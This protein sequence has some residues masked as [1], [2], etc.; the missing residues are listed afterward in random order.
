MDLWHL[1]PFDSGSPNARDPGPSFSAKCVASAMRQT[2]PTAMR[3]AA[4]RRRS[5]SRISCAPP[6]C[7]R[8][9][10][11]VPM[12][13]PSTSLRVHPGLSSCA[14]PGRCANSPARSRATCWDAFA[15]M[16]SAPPGRCVAQ[17][18]ARRTVGTRFLL[19]GLLA[20]RTDQKQPRIPRLTGTACGR[21]AS[22]R[23]EVQQQRIETQKQI[24]R[25]FPPDSA[26]KSQDRSLGPPQNAW[27]PV[28]SG[29]QRRGPQSSSP[30]EPW[31]GEDAL[32]GSADSLRKNPCNHS[33]IGRI[34]VG[35]LSAL[36][37]D[38]HFVSGLE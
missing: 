9:A 34:L 20:L 10:A 2:L 13:P 37:A 22:R 19:E 32:V 38:L 27:G 17:E 1:R 23:D 8:Q 21:R 7:G 28:R 36:R 5:S 31:R 11:A 14:P 6:G 16:S 18:A 33:Q 26:P 15:A 35:T 12:V 4:P 25:S 29:G 30:R 3:F 24:P